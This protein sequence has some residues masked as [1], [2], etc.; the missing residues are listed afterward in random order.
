M[1]VWSL[2]RFKVRDWIGNILVMRFLNEVRWGLR[3]EFC[4]VNVCIEGFVSKVFLILSFIV[5]DSFVLEKIGYGRGCMFIVFINL[6]IIKEV[7]NI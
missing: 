7:L 1:W 2:E 5:C 6:Y 4:C 3:V